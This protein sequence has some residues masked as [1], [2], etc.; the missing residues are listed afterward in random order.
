MPTPPK[1]KNTSGFSKLEPILCPVEL[2]SQIDHLVKRMSE[3][4][5]RQPITRAMV[6]REVMAH[7]VE[8][9]TRAVDATPEGEMFQPLVDAIT[10][11]RRRKAGT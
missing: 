2:L 4:F 9:L 1:S 8:A 6:V 5:P 10:P 11:G 7:G 3:R